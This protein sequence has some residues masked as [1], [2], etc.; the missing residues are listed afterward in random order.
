MNI[1]ENQIIPVGAHNLSK[2]FRPNLSTIRVL[3][4]GMKFI[5]RSEVPKWKNVFSKFQD[6]RRRMNNKMFFFVE[7][8]PGT[9]E[10]MIHFESKVRGSSQRN[11]M[12]S[13]NFFGTFENIC[14]HCSNREF[15]LEK[16]PTYP[17]KKH[18]HSGN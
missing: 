6:F 18:L 8:I 3:S 7:K 9:F 1:F 17:T 15:H 11:A 10:K 14:K 16:V 2:S 13:T 12:T 5:P 4:L